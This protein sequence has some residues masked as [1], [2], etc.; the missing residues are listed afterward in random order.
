MAG[1]LGLLLALLLSLLPALAA[2]CNLTDSGEQAVGALEE[3][4]GALQG[5]A[6]PLEGTADMG[7]GIREVLLTSG[8]PGTE[9][10]CIVRVEECRGPVDC[11]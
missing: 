4:T 11:G 3:S 8:C 5:S 10:K 2:E 1:C 7:I 6:E 9:E